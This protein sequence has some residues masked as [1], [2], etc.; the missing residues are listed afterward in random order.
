MTQYQDE[1][2]ALM[3]LY[4]AIGSHVRTSGCQHRDLCPRVMASALVVDEHD[5]VLALWEAHYSRWGLPRLLPDA[6]DASLF[7]TAE[8]AAKCTTGI[9]EVYQLASI[10]GPVDIEFRR[11]IRGREARLT[12]IFRFLFRSYS[13]ELPQPDTGHIQWREIREL[14]PPRIESRLRTEYLAES[15]WSRHSGLAV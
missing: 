1:A 14:V 10:T 2:A 8:R 13:Y 5:R 3:P 6:A 9:G 4:N 11:D 7:E 12:Y 15:R